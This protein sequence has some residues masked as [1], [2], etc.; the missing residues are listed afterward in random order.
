MY[1]M[2][3][4]RSVSRSVATVS[5]YSPTVH[6]ICCL[7]LVALRLAL[8]YCDRVAY[9]YRSTFVNSAD[10]KR[11]EEGAGDAPIRNNIRTLVYNIYKAA[12]SIAASIFRL[13]PSCLPAYCFLPTTSCN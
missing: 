1:T 3:V 9:V 8:S 13:P 7:L 5:H 2:M 12:K 6:S 4:G 11:I 10:C